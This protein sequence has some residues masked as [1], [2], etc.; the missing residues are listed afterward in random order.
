MK[1]IAIENVAVPAGVE[2]RQL[3]SYVS[4]RRKSKAAF[5]VGKTLQ[6]TSNLKE[7]Q[8]SLK[9]QVQEMDADWVKKNGQGR[10][11]AH[12]KIKS[13]A[14]ISKVLKIFFRK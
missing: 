6:L 2:V 1:A 7:L 11:K 13:E 8:K 10:V 4:F 5:L 14:D 9:N 12:A 3:K